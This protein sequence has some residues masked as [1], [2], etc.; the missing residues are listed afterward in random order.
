MTLEPVILELVLHQFLLDN[1]FN[2]VFKFVQVSKL[3]MSVAKRI[4][5]S[6]IFALRVWR[7]RIFKTHKVIKDA[8]NLSRLVDDGKMLVS[9]PFVPYLYCVLFDIN[10]KHPFRINLEWAISSP[11][12]RDV[13]NYSNTWNLGLDAL[14][15]FSWSH[16]ENPQNF[17]HIPYKPLSEGMIE[18]YRE[19]QFKEGEHQTGKGNLPFK[20]YKYGCTMNYRDCVYKYIVVTI[21]DYYKFSIQV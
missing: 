17:P 16:L 21:R 6:N 12:V 10:V 9:F 20:F 13:L 5:S 2:T 3:F 11:I 15:I 8:K 7:K 18:F 4:T 14:K 19:R 1:D